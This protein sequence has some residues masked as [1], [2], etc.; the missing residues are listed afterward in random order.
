MNA[1]SSEDELYRAAVDMQVYF[2]KFIQNTHSIYFMR[3]IVVDIIQIDE[4]E[5]LELHQ[6][7]QQQANTSDHEVFT[8]NK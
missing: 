3:I 4:Q 2:D 6:A 8:L 1:V 7:A 5:Q